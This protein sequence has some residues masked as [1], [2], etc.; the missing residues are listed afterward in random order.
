MKRNQ[1]EYLAKELVKERQQSNE[2]VTKITTLQQDIKRWQADHDKVLRCL[3]D[4]EQREA[5]ATALVQV[6]ETTDKSDLIRSSMES[7]TW[8]H[9]INL[10]RA[11]T[12]P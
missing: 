6:A 12:R 11:A 7:V 8:R 4:F 2:L 9:A 5:L 10:L 3:R 1:Q